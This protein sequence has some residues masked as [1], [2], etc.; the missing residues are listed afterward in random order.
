M[1]QSKDDVKKTTAEPISD[2]PSQGSTWLRWDP[3]IHTPGTALN[4]QYGGTT[5][6]DFCSKIE[7]SSPK[8]SCLGVTD[9]LSIKAYSKIVEQKAIGRLP[10]VD[11]IFPNV[12][13]RL[14]VG[15]VQGSAVN[16]H[17]LFSPEDPNHIREIERFLGRLK[18]R[19]LDE[20]YAC[21]KDDL[22]SLGRKHDSGLVDDTAAYRQGVNQF[23]LT[24]DRLLDELRNSDWARNNCLVAVAASSNDGTS[25]V[26]SED[27][28]LAS[29]RVHIEAQS[30]LLDQGRLLI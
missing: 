5:V 17:L 12:E 25:G 20:E 24:Q 28:S 13:F 9:Y 11:L 19:Y 16:A 21:T 27:G 29:L 26:R 4:N 22:I 3:H 14:A 8:I 18:F 30:I 10:D 2:L 1:S 6:E 7:Q 15:T 23:K